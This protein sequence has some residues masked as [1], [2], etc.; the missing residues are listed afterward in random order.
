MVKALQVGIVQPLPVTS[1]AV[2]PHTAFQQVKVGGKVE[3]EI[4]ITGVIHWCWEAI[5]VDFPV[6]AED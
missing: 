2:H 4:F 6:T 3:P 5:A 1:P